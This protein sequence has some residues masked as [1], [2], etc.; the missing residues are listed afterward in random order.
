MVENSTK[1]HAHQILFRKWF[2]SKFMI[3]TLFS[4]EEK[5]NRSVFRDWVTHTSVRGR[6]R[7]GPPRES[8][9]AHHLW[10]MDW[11]RVVSHLRWAGHPL[12]LECLKQLTHICK[13]RSLCLEPVSSTRSK[14]L[15][16]GLTLGI[17]EA[18]E[19]FRRCCWRGT[20]W[21][22]VLHGVWRFRVEAQRHTTF[23]A[24]KKEKW[25]NNCKTISV[26]ILK[27]CT[28]LRQDAVLTHI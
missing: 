28:C 25:N 19:E 21:C 6:G 11:S 27:Q 13:G 24:W 8:I 9:T 15:C 4:S 16:L 17:G 14:R 7:G 18:R 2:R 10:G 5:F 22:C 26:S 1:N 20:V 3:L 12:L 23:G